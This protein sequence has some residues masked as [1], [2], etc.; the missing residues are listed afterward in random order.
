MKVYCS[1][2]YFNGKNKNYKSFHKKIADSRK[3]DIS[4]IFKSVDDISKKEITRTKQMIDDHFLFFNSS[5]VVEPIYVEPSDDDF[6]TQ[7]K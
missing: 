5:T 1:T 2:S 7:S 3:I 4:D 6:F